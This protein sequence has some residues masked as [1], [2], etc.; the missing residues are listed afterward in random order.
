GT[1]FTPLNHYAP[2]NVDDDGAVVTPAGMATTE[3][4]N[5]HLVDPS[6][7]PPSTS[8]DILLDGLFNQ[9]RLLQ[10]VRSYVSFDAGED[11]LTRRVAKP[12]QYFAVSM[13]VRATVPAVE[14]DVRAGIVWHTQG[15]RKSME[16][17]LFA[18][19]ASRHPK[20]HN[21]TI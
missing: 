12:H 5:L 3:Q 21:P 17:E 18:A 20:L 13:A 9:T 14:G 15:S 10:L 19:Q 16:M 1:P 7:E 6:A 2:W 11:G 8:L 4:A